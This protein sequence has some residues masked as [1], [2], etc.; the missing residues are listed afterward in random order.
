MTI[1]PSLQLPSL[2]SRRR[3]TFSPMLSVLLGL[4]LWGMTG[5]DSS[6]VHAQEP[7]ET[8]PS[9]LTTLITGIEA[10]ANRQDV[11]GVLEFY[12]ED[13]STTEGLDRRSLE[14]VLN[15]L[16][17][18]YSNINY[19]TQLQSWEKDGSAILATTV[20]EITG[21]QDLNGREFQLN[22][23]ITSQQ[24]VENQKVVQQ[25]VLAE[26]NQLT[27]GQEPPTVTLIVPEQVKTGQEYSIDAI[28]EEPLGDQIMIGTA[29]EERVTPRAY[30]TEFPLELEFL[31]SGGVFK[32]GTA[33]KTPGNNWISA[34]L[35]R[36]GGI[37]MVTQ[38]LKIVER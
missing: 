16:W 30:L 8:A 37:T 5:V 14:Q 10:A 9:E 29:I 20:T 27:S 7:P 36:P 4:V 25:E 3:Q 19:Q 11:D 23:T 24:R 31:P 17:Q 38:R 21:T 2:V 13:F 18:N 22:S 28:V 15:Q 6:R 26:R 34:I 12:S 35:M 32:I 1:F 33:P